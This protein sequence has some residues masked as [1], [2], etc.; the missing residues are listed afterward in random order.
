MRGTICAPHVY[1]VPFGNTVG[2]MDSRRDLGEFLTAKRGQVSPESAQLPFTLGQRRVSGLRREEVALLAGISDTYYTR[3]ERGRVHSVSDAVLRGLVSALQL[4]PQEADYVAASLAVPGWKLAESVESRST[5]VPPTLQ[6]LIDGLADQ[7][8]LVLN[9][10]CDYVAHNAI[11]RA[12]YVHHFPVESATAVVPVNSIRFMFT[13]PR[14]RE[15]YV[16]W[17]RAA[18]QGVAFLRSSCARYP[19]DKALIAL[20][21]ELRTSSQDFASMWARRAV[22]F[23][24]EGTRS[25]LHP[26]VGQLDLEY[27]TLL[28]VGYPALRLTTYSAPTG[29]PSSARLADL[30]QEVARSAR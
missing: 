2:D 15:F 28:V 23:D 3:L 7:P 1:R 9:E 22:H 19:K 8:V 21:A 17:Q 5:V 20:V 18:D 12:L 27:Q 10:G 4:T 16:D 30:A 24:P 11:A 14:A 26:Q 25:L 29:S 13:D 6:R